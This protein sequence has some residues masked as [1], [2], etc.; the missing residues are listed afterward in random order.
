ML[1]RFGNDTKF[2][3]LVICGCWGFWWILMFI[4]QSLLLPDNELGR[5]V[6]LSTTLGIVWMLV[7][8][9]VFFFSKIIKYRNSLGRLLLLHFIGATVVLVLRTI[10]Q[11]F[12]IKAFFNDKISFWDLWIQVLAGF[13]VGSYIIYGFIASIHY[14]SIWF[15]E[16]KDSE[17]KSLTLKFKSEQLERQLSEANLTTLRMQLN[18]H[19]LFNTLNSVASLIRTK[20][21]TAAIETLST[22][23]EF[24]RTTVYD[25][26]K[27]EVTIREEVDFIERYLTIEQMRFSDRLEVTWDIEDVVLDHKIPTFLLQPLVENALKHGLKDTK[28]GKL[29]I[30]IKKADENRIVILIEDNGAGLPIGLPLEHTQGVGLKNTVNRLQGTYHDQ[31]EFRISNNS[32][33]SGAHVRLILPMRNKV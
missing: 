22:L 32:K 20:K 13:L 26:M 27:N 7:T 28:N 18:P 23:S 17:M 12:F 19:F 6:I 14:A 24:L 33:A 29:N 1:E 5:Q 15:M 11:T 31:Y 2:T 21:N 8:P 16:Y 10:P 4:Q 30:S 3:I 9:L 25:G